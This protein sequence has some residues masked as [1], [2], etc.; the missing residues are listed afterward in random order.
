MR[1]NGLNSMN[2]YPKENLTHFTSY[3]FKSN[4]AGPSK[5]GIIPDNRTW[6]SEV[7][8]CL[9]AMIKFLPSY[10]R[11]SGA[12]GL[13]SAKNKFQLRVSTK[14]IISMHKHKQKTV[15][16]FNFSFTK[17]ALLVH[18]PTFTCDKHTSPKLNRSRTA[19]SAEGNPSLSLPKLSMCLHQRATW[20]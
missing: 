19:G 1:K 2:Y 4:L 13:N 6:V 17:T 11:K 14:I 20:G 8:R 3:N 15:K 18:Q 10:D 16:T 9:P 5:R 7:I 12:N